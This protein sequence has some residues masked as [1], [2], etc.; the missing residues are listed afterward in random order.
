MIRIKPTYAKMI[1][2]ITI[3]EAPKELNGIKGFCNSKQLCNEHGFYQVVFAE[4][5]GDIATY[6]L[7]DNKIIQSWATIDTEK[8]SSDVISR[9]RLVYSEN[10]ELAILR[11][12][13]S[14]IDSKGFLAYNVY[15]EKVKHDVK[16]NMITDINN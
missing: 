10:E 15:C 9:I 11:K 12:Q 13:L 7:I 14:G 1:D 5:N 6:E 3:E 8:Y 2:L 16:L 4:K